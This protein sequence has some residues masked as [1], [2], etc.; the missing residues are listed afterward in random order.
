VNVDVPQLDIY[1]P[2]KWRLAIADKNGRLLNY[3]S[4]QVAPA[5]GVAASWRKYGHQ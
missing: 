4:T 5:W 2:P 3:L 1:A